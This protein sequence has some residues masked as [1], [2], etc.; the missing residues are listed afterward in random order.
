MREIETVAV[1][2][3]GDAGAALAIGA[4]LA[5]CTVRLQDDDGRARDAAFDAIR[6]RVEAGCAS[7]ALTAAERQRVLD[8]VL[9]TADLD[10]AVTSADLVVAPGAAD[11]VVLGVRLAGAAELVRATA[12][13]AGTVQRAVDAVAGALPQPGRLLALAL[14]EVG[15][16]VPRLDARAAPTTSLH[17]LEVARG[18]AARVNR[19]ARLAP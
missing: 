5:G 15:G 11:P 17:A 12:V 3:T 7:G 14:D 16:P 9:I 8:G 13:L 4:A 19:A 6:R 1:I 10:E 2:G 18:F